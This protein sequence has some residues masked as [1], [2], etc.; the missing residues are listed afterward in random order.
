MSDKNSE[1]SRETKLINGSSDG[2][3]KS[4]KS[5]GKVVLERKI[6]LI[7]GVTIIIG[8]IIGSGIF[9][10]PTGVFVF[11]ESVGAS[12]VIWAVCGILSTL[13]ALCY[14]EL[15]TCITRSG[16]DYAYLLVAFGPL[17]AFLRL[18]IALFIIR[19]TTQA[20]IALTFAQYAAKPFF[21]D[22]QPPEISVRLLAALCLCLLTAINCIST[23]LAMKIQDVFTAAKL[24]AL[25]SIILAGCFYM[26]MGHLQN[27]EDPWTG[28]YDAASLGYAFYSG[29]FAFGGWNYL[30]FVTGE[31]QD[32]Y[33]ARNDHLLEINGVWSITTS[34]NEIKREKATLQVYLLDKVNSSISKLIKNT[35]RFTRPR[36][37]LPSRDKRGTSQKAGDNAEFVTFYVIGHYLNFGAP[38]TSINE[39]LYAKFSEKSFHTYWRFAHS[40]ASFA[41]ISCYSSPF[42]I[43]I[44]FHWRQWEMDCLT[45]PHTCFP[46]GV[47]ANALSDVLMLKI[48]LHC[49]LLTPKLDIEDNESLRLREGERSQLQRDNQMPHKSHFSSSVVSDNGSIGTHHTR[50]AFHTSAGHDLPTGSTVPY[51]TEVGTNPVN[52]VAMWQTEND[53]NIGEDN[54]QCEDMDIDEH[55]PNNEPSSM[56]YYGNQLSSCDDE[57]AEMNKPNRPKI[58][59][60]E[61]IMICPPTISTELDEPMEPIENTAAQPMNKK[62]RYQ[63]FSQPITSSEQMITRAAMNQR[64]I[65]NNLQT[66]HEN[67]ADTFTVIPEGRKHKIKRSVLTSTE[68]I[69]EKKFKYSESDS[70]LSEEMDETLS[71]PNEYEVF[72][73]NATSTQVHSKENQVDQSSSNQIVPMH[74]TTQNLTQ[75][76]TQNLSTSNS[77]QPRNQETNENTTE[78]QDRSRSQQTLM[79]RNVFKEPIQV[80]QRTQMVTQNRS[81]RSR[82]TSM[83]SSSSKQQIQGIKGTQTVSKDA[84]QRSH[85]TSVAGSS[86]QQPIQSVK[87]TQKLSQDPSLRSHETSIAG[88]SSRQPI[89]GIKGT[90]TVSKDAS[91]RS[92]ETSIAGSSSQQPIQG[93]EGTQTVAQNRSLRAQ[94]N[95]K[96]G[97]SSQQPIEGIKGTQTVS[98]DASRRSHETSTAGS[99]SQQ[100]IQ[101]IKGTQT[102]AQNRSL[103]SQENSKAGNSSQQPIEGI[104]GTETVTQNR[105][106]RSHDTSIVGSSSQQPIEGIKGIQTVSKDASRR[107]HET[108]IAGSSSQKPIQSVKGTQKLSQDPSLRSYET[109]IAGSSSQQPIQGI[110]GTQT[111]TQNRSLRSHETSIAG[112]S[113]QQPI[114]GIKGTQTVSKDASRRSHETSIA[115]SSSQQ[116]IQ[117]IKGTQTVTQNRSLRS[118]ET[119]IAGSSSQQ[120][121]QGIKGTQ[122]MSRDASRRSHQTSTAG[123]SSQQLIQDPSQSMRSDKTS[124]ARD[125]L[126]EPIE[127]IY[128][129]ATAIEPSTESSAFSSELF[130]SHIEEEGETLTNSIPTKQLVAG[131]PN[132]PMK[133]MH[134]G[135]L[136][137]S[138][139]RNQQTNVN[140]SRKVN[141]SILKAKA[142]P[143]R[144]TL[145]KNNLHKKCVI[146]QALKAKVKPTPRTTRN[147]MKTSEEIRQDGSDWKPKYSISSRAKSLSRRVTED[148]AATSITEYDMYAFDND[149]ELQKAT[150]F[151]IAN[152][153]L[154]LLKTEH[155]KTLP[156]GKRQLYEM[157][158]KTIHRMLNDGLEKLHNRD[159]PELRET[160]VFAFPTTK[161]RE[162]YRR[163]SVGA[164]SKVF[165]GTTK[166]QEK[167]SL[168]ERVGNFFSKRSEAPQS[169]KSNLVHTRTAPKKIPIYASTKMRSGIEQLNRDVA[170][171]Q[172]HASAEMTYAPPYTDENETNDDIP[173]HTEREAQL[174]T[175]VLACRLD[176]LSN[177]P[178]VTCK[179]TCIHKRKLSQLIDRVKN[180][181][182]GNDL[183]FLESFCD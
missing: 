130:V 127:G 115:G 118:H 113:S 7:N 18:W 75:T 165:D 131:T 1:A 133:E 154:D 62:V 57:P 135:V 129:T 107:S 33:N 83:P 90:Q 70:D 122:T 104:K 183:T 46:L 108:S 44:R 148:T 2:S 102:V 150:R 167:T 124:I 15:G 81:L 125:L 61:D 47:F 42:Y 76:L 27:F 158:I 49:S 35:Y 110:K 11:T 156:A 182:N 151:Y 17:V 58:E 138:I 79:N 53:P 30:N 55:L 14:A 109:S 95:S 89:E 39:R 13:G 21:P 28:R 72:L 51:L 5:D 168:Q 64:T 67:P 180:E 65:A 56:N 145:P 157:Q 6:T 23:K 152:N 149:D 94:E 106:L 181:F 87:G 117:G 175:D 92:H 153:G 84:S 98:K 48:A 136:T 178:I 60:L 139:Q 41:P 99:S 91:R 29:L 37:K 146:K 132:E 116:P 163:V 179:A 155:F 86:S 105:Y 174:C 172:R 173:R 20:I 147:Y 66:Y 160:D 142:V 68:N 73:P 32:P 80:I 63:T 112:S 97:N 4:E 143:K 36:S 162:I 120:P 164:I 19:P 134:T 121:I 74:E 161:S 78:T 31:L 54:L 22:C 114:E 38:N 159:E 170:Q 93:I 141:D 8:T 71:S 52:P 85:E 128:E 34:R 9:I 45:I 100:P 137:A 16:G 88:S 103:R 169:T 25:I 43:G 69:L 82:R 126:Q 111:V 166:Q 140:R 144:F 3:E 12:L 10:S 26:A 123:S 40:F 77:A 119:S 24:L 59:I 171:Q 101:G 96:A 177:E 176:E 50:E